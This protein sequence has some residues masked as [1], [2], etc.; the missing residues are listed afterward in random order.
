[1]QG[2]AKISIPTKSFSVYLIFYCYLF[3]KDPFGNKLLAFMGYPL[4]R[5]RLFIYKYFLECIQDNVKIINNTGIVW[6]IGRRYIALA[7]DT[8]LNNK[9]TN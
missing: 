6:N 1:M 5:S 7:A 3:L 4:E 8:V 2:Y 9:L